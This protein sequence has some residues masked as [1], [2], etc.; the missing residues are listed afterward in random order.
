MWRRI[1][2]NSLIFGGGAIVMAIL[3]AAYRLLAID[4]LSVSHY[5]QVALIISIF[6]GIQLAG[7]AGVPVA[8]ARLGARLDRP[9]DR[10]LLGNALRASALPCLLAALAMI[11]VTLA[12]LGS[13]DAAAIAAAGMPALVLSAMCQG[14][15]QGRDRIF[16]AASIQ[17]VNTIAQLVVLI[18][19]IAVGTDVGVGW[20]MTSFYIGNVAAL[21]YGAAMV[22][23]RADLAE[24]RPA[25]EDVRPSRILGFSLYL[26]MATLAVFL[27]PILSRIGVANLSYAEVAIFDLAL[28]LY[29]IPERLAA[30]IVSAL[31]PVA[32]HAQSR[33]RRV[34]IPGRRDVVLLSAIIGAIA[35]VLWETHAARA[36]LEAVGLD[37]YTGA[38]PLLLIVLVAA[39]AELFFMLNAGLLSAFGQSRRLAMLAG[40]VFAVSLVLVPLATLLGAEALAALL[41]LDFWVL[42]LGSSAILPEA[43]I[44]RRRISLKALSGLRAKR[45]PA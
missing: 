33:A 22:F 43:D 28:L 16:A 25:N 45:V 6:N 18:A 31:I 37:R 42:Y 8:L 38:E 39:P 1:G 13:W 23:R 11:G 17:P 20:V 36:A 14:Y 5:G 41:V 34:A 7:Q 15:L 3:Q 21:A 44:E 2:R 12:I 10:T 29:S 30:S 4:E 40:A 32:A 9:D 26:T 35:L 19:V 27:L 24:R